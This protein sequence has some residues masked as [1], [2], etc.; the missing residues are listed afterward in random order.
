MRVA[1]ELLGPYQ[2]RIDA[3]TLVPGPRGIFDVTV[4]GDLIFSKYATKRHAERGEVL[5]I[6]RGIVGGG[7]REYG[8]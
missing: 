2:H 6:F 1:E 5:E 8:T 3:L 4:N 7:V